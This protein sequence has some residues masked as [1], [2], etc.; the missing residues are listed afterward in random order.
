[1]F[2]FLINFVETFGKVQPEVKAI[3]K[4]IE[5]CNNYRSYVYDKIRAIERMESET[6]PKIKRRM[7]LMIDE[8][9]YDFTGIENF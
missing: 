4:G 6:N 8:G 7:Q 1:M 5:D 9:I 2:E 3:P